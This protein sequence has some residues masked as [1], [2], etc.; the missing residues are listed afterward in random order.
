MKSDSVSSV[1]EESAELRSRGGR[2]RD[3]SRLLRRRSE[4]CR[5]RLV[6]AAEGMDSVA[7]SLTAG[8]E[9]DGEA[10][11]GR[12]VRA[13]TD[14]ESAIADCSA[15]LADVRRELEWRDAGPASI[16]H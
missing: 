11:L 6:R 12:L 7:A 1:R 5:R 14:L 13:E 3:L 8:Q 15:A 16:V 4:E 2:L 9:T 10:R